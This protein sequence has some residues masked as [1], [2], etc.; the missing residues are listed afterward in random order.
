MRISGFAVRIGAAFWPLW[1]GL[2]RIFVSDWC[3]S[4]G[5][6]PYFAFWRLSISVPK[7]Q[8]PRIVWKPG[9]GVENSASK[10]A[11]RV[12]NE[13]LNRAGE[14]IA[15]V[16]GPRPWGPPRKRVPKCLKGPETTYTTIAISEKQSKIS[17]KGLFL[18]Y[19]GPLVPPR[20]WNLWGL[21]GKVPPNPP[22][23]PVSPAMVLK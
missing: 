6:M 4:S 22:P 12:E 9:W 18:L 10:C 3:V 13:V 17:K 14:M 21:E 1:C 5:P 23:P 2:V 7:L 8:G 15:E 20:K 11:V 16:E 19:I